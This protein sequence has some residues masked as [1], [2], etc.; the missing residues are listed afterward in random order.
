MT[1]NQA[2]WAI[3]MA[4]CLYFHRLSAPVCAARFAILLYCWDKASLLIGVRIAAA[5]AVATPYFLSCTKCT[6][7]TYKHPA[8]SVVM[9]DVVAN[10]KITAF[11]VFICFGRCWRDLPPSGHWNASAADRDFACGE[12]ST[13]VSKLRTK[14]SSRALDRG[15]VGRHNKTRIWPPNNLTFQQELFSKW[16]R[17]HDKQ[18]EVDLFLNSFRLSTQLDRW[19][20]VA[21]VQH[22]DAARQ[23]TSQWEWIRGGGPFSNSRL[24]DEVRWFAGQITAHVA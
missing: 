22:H 24:V 18:D 8:L 20:E 2:V 23:P 4:Q 1:N 16:V 21:G 19:D 15:T 11:C 14:Q 3:G 5:A 6:V 17:A 12:A 7:A 9:H 13:P 10:L